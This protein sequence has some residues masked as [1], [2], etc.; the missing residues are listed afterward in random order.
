MTYTSVYTF[1]FQGRIFKIEVEEDD[2]QIKVEIDGKAVPVEFQ[3]IEENLYSILFEGKSITLGVIN[4]GNNTQ[5]FLNGDLY[6]L[7]S[8]SERDQRKSTHT[9]SGMQEIKS[10][11]PSRIVKILKGEGDEVEVDE[12][13]IVIEAMKMESELKSPVKGNIKDIFVKEGDAVEAG[14]VLLVVSSE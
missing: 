14:T 8:I 7:E 9:V 12:S 13:V 5:I 2:N 10:P 4:K 11:M 1:R 6:Q 3:K